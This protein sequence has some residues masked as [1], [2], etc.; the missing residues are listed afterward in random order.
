MSFENLLSSASAIIRRQRVLDRFHQGRRQGRS[1][2]LALLLVVTSSE[3][4]YKAG[5]NTLPE[6]VAGI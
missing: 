5:L 6:N 2:G 1:R 4:R 3:M